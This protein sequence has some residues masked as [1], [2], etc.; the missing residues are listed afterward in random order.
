MPTIDEV[1]HFHKLCKEHKDL[2]NQKSRDL[3]N[4]IESGEWHY[5]LQQFQQQLN[6]FNI[7]CLLPE[8]TFSNERRLMLISFSVILFLCFGWLILFGRESWE[9]LFLIGGAVYGLFM[10]FDYPHYYQSKIFVDHI[11]KFDK[12]ELPLKR[13]SSSNESYTEQLSRLHSLFKSG[14]LTEEEF[15]EQKKKILEKAS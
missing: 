9:L 2:Y 3:Q 7:F 14:A 11:E 10:A 13:Q 6:S 1:K 4:L 15:Q 8:F 12:G 5:P